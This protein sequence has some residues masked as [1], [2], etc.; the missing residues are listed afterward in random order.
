MSDNKI[1]MRSKALLSIVAFFTAFG[2]S[3]ALTPQ[4][5][6]S[7]FTAPYVKTCSARSETARRITNLLEQDIANGQARDNKVNVFKESEFSRQKFAVKY[8][9][10]VSDYA[11]ASN[12]IDDSDLPSDF[13]AAWRE[14][15]QVW[16]EHSDFLNE[17]TG[18][19]PK[20]YGYGSGSGNGYSSKTYSDQNREISRTWYEVL[21]LARTYDAYIPADAY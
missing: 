3:V 9:A 2:I 7:T 5:A 21:R 16:K 1:V 18:Y 10:A 6:K 4:A 15:M 19:S 13:R 14:H 17:R 11:Y 8:A 12:S 20:T